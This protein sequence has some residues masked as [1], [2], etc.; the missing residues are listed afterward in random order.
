L[1][2]FVHTPLVAAHMQASS[3][4]YAVVMAAMRLDAIADGLGGSSEPAGL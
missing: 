3:F 1:P 4:E 2:A